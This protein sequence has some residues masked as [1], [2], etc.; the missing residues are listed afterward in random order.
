MSV[1]S[2]WSSVVCSIHSWKWNI[3]VS[4]Y[5]PVIC[6]SLQF[7]QCLLPSFRS[8]AIWY[9]H[10]YNCY[11]F[12][13]NWSF[14]YFIIFFFVSSKIFDLNCVLFNAIIAIALILF[15]PL[16]NSESLV[17]QQELDTVSDRKIEALALHR[18]CNKLVLKPKMNPSLS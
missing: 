13:V 12:L 16:W 4:C 17:S 15:N 11:I 3:E 10:I 8:S 7:C 2:S 6:F 1:R 5:Y 9:V 18:F 14:Y